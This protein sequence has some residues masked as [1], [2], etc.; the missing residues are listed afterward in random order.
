MSLAHTVSNFYPITY[1]FI[2]DMARVK[3]ASKGDLCYF[4]IYMLFPSNM[5]SIT[6]VGHENVH[7]M[8]GSNKL[9]DA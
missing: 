5:K 2:Q 8:L 3:Q 7:C 1:F 4:T 6:V 9:S